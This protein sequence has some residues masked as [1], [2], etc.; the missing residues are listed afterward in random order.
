MTILQ[1]YERKVTELCIHKTI[2]HFQF[3]DWLYNAVGPFML[4]KHYLDKTPSK[5][6]DWLIVRER[7]DWHRFNHRNICA[8][9]V[10]FDVD[11]PGWL[12]DKERDSILNMT[13]RRLKEKH[14][15]EPVVF[16]TGK[17]YHLHYLSTQIASGMLT[18]SNA[19]QWKHNW[20]MEI[21][22]DVRTDLMKW[23][24]A[25]MIAIE[26]MAHWKRP[27]DTKMLLTTHKVPKLVINKPRTLSNNLR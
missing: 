6:Y 3:L 7:K 9:E 18:A 22:T 12:Q 8:C 13:L 20:A 27:E 2:D 19:K 25:T 24:H 11:L 23:N 21:L 10:I 1:N 15:I 16:S 26:G 4:Q 17:G 14:D 5:W